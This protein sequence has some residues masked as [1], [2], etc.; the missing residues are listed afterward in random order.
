ML[1]RALRI[2]AVATD[3]GLVAECAAA[4]TAML[5]DVRPL[6]TASGGFYPIADTTRSAAKRVDH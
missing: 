4:V 1:K 6:P 5:G 3:R 2:I